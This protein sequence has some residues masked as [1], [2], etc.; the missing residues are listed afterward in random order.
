MITNSNALI[1]LEAAKSL[2]VKAEVIQEKP[3][4]IDLTHNNQTHQIRAKTFNLNTDPQAKQTAKNKVLT[5][6]TLALAGLPTPRQATVSSLENY[7]DISLPFP[8]VV[9][10]PMGEKGKQIY[11][12]LKTPEL[13]QR[14]LKKVLANH[15]EGAL[16]ET[17]HQGNDYRFLCLNFKVIGLAQRLPPTITGDGHFTIEKL[18]DLENQHRLEQNQTANKR[19]LNRIRLNDRLDFYLDLQDFSLDDIL[20]E[21]QTITLFP[22]P[23]FSTGGSVTTVD[24]NTIH[25]D[26]IALAETAAQT[27]NLEICGIDVLIK[28]LTKPR[29]DNA[30]IIEINSDPGLR[31][32]D[33]PNQGKPQHTGATILKSIFNL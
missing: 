1:L 6:Q 16:V 18:I 30:T 7:P 21:N 9:K 29:Q 19:L 22:I 5:G 20:P 11:L 8:Q 32:H 28:D 23:N 14:A 25:Q 33:W 2:G 12:D 17:Y 10:P 3:F 4:I 26:L 24:P 31:L 15:P 27:I 13:A